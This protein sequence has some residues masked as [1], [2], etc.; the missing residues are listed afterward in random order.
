MAYSCLCIFGWR[1]VSKVFVVTCMWIINNWS[2]EK[3]IFRSYRAT[4]VTLL[5]HTRLLSFTL[6]IGCCYGDDGIKF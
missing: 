4:A 5:D 1:D 2:I 3:E 6:H